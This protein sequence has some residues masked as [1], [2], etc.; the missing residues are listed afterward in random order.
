MPSD[1][2]VPVIVVCVGVSRIVGWRRQW[3]HA[4]LVRCWLCVILQV[5][6]IATSSAI[7][8]DVRRCAGP[9][10]RRRPGGP[11]NPAIISRID[12]AGPV[13]SFAD[14]GG[15]AP[16]EVDFSTLLALQLSP[17]HLEGSGPNNSNGEIVAFV[18]VSRSPSS[19]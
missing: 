1:V 11:A 4:M 5:V 18:A 3:R 19:G 13:A 7:G 16:R 6:F 14:G 12:I 2:V 9:V 8:T 15:I 10:R 17:A